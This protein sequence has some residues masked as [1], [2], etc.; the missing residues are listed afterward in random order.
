MRKLKK[1]I[2]FKTKEEREDFWKKLKE[3]SSIIKL[4][5][6]FPFMYEIE[7]S[8]ENISLCLFHSF[9]TCGITPDK[10][11]FYNCSLEDCEDEDVKFSLK[12]FG[13]KM[14]LSINSEA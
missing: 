6:R 1:L 14:Q 13:N 5:F 7:T 2:F 12:M 11:I 4:D 3:I 8:N 9:Y 10:I